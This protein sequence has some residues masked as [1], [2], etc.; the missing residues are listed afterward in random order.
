MSRSILLIEDDADV[1][2]T[3]ARFFERRGWLVSGAEG[4]RPGLEVYDRERPDLVLLD[5][6]LPDLPGLDV[7]RVLRERDSAAAVI[8]L[9]GYGDIATAVAAMRLGAENFLTKPVE[10]PHLEAAA[11]RALEKVELRRL[12]RFLAEREGDAPGLG[13]LGRSPVMREIVRQIE[14][15]AAS[16]TTV[17]LLGETGTGK[18][19]VAKLLHALSPRAGAPLIE[20]NCG[21]LTATFL[22][23]ELFGH[24]RGAFTDAKAQK[25]GLFEIAHT[26]TLLL[27]EIG[28]L[29]PE[30]Q[31]KLLNVL[32]SRTFR[33]LGGTREIEV[34]VRL[35][36]ATHHPLEDAVRAGRFRE[37]LYYRLAVLPLRLPP[38]RERGPQD[39][40]ELARRLLLDLR[41]RLGRGP[42]RFSA[43]ALDLLTRYSW[44][45]NIRELRNVLERVLL[46]G[47]GAEEVLPAHLPT[48]LTSVAGPPGP[49]SDP[50]LS[51]DELERR[52][53]ARVLAH[54]AGNRSRA[55]RTLGI[56]RAALYQKLRRYGLEHV[57]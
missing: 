19:W 56:S 26:G 14:L 28:D 48:E 21:G 6:E 47:A 44:P 24:E 36:A 50:G 8:M 52:H 12:S 46:L 23:S 17:L 43:E 40:A 3:L 54:H 39:I 51:L 18:G 41:R 13:S 34:D 49:D 31:P 55:A 32:E 2:A 15:L 57:S 22:D 30:L 1:R 42:G 20:V 38:L 33:R 11:E 7:L 9:T 45:G 27:D 37:D 10:L 25:R 29:A 4:G 53:I 16:D 5:L 35:I